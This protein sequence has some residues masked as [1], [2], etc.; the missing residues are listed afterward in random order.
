MLHPTHDGILRIGTIMMLLLMMTT[1]SRCTAF[2]VPRIRP[3]ATRALGS[4]IAKSCYTHQQQRAT[5]TTR[6]FS[7][8]T[9]SSASSSSASASTVLKRVK[10]IDAV[11]PTEDPVVIKGWVKTIRKQKTLA[12]VQVNDGSNM[13]GI[14]CVVSFDDIDEQTMKG[15]CLIIVFS[16]VEFLA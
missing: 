14:Q 1:M 10:T 2:V 12:F 3:T 15:T 13:K 11:E 9:E 7:A 16:S 4:T 8:T 6:L 5:A